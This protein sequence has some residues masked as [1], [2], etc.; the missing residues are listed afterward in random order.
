V[1][2]RLQSL[3]YQPSCATSTTGAH[4]RAAGHRPREAT[5]GH[6]DR[7][8]AGRNH[9]RVDRVGRLDLALA[10]AGAKDGVKA[11]SDQTLAAAAVDV[12]RPQLAGGG[13][14]REPSGRSAAG[15]GHAGWRAG[16]G[17]RGPWASPLASTV[18]DRSRARPSIG[19]QPDEVSARRVAAPPIA[20][21]NPGKVREA[22]EAAAKLG[23]KTSAVLGALVHLDD[24]RRCGF[25]VVRD[26]DHDRVT[27]GQGERHRGHDGHCAMGGASDSVGG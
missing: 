1:A 9:D 7:T 3:S 25:V 11:D 4:R 8:A 14:R 23:G 21:S 27:M 13:R 24:R 10:T 17:R 18:R 16:S 12:G 19:I 2:V 26:P 5:R 20:L 6:A 15:A 22:V